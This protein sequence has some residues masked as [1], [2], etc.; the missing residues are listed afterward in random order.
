MVGTEKRLSLVFLWGSVG[1]NHPTATGLSA[2]PGSDPREDARGHKVLRYLRSDWA[3]SGE[4]WHEPSNGYVGCGGSRWDS[5]RKDARGHKTIVVVPDSV[6]TPN[7]LLIPA[8]RDFEGIG[9]E[10][11]TAIYIL[12]FRTRHRKTRRGPGGFLSQ[13]SRRPLVEDADKSVGGPRGGPSRGRS[14][15]QDDRGGP[16]FSLHPQPPPHFPHESSKNKEGAR[17]L[18]CLKSPVDRFW[19]TP[20][21][22]SAVLGADP[23]ED[24]RGHETIGTGSFRWGERWHE[25]SNGYG[26]RVLRSV[27]W[28]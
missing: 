11:S 17:R 1:T 27:V 3:H 25:P 14:G 13:I 19:Q 21:G 16:G 28:V 26:G 8:R 15:P 12:I 9:A 5:P 20:T 6:S 7:P 24:A 10:I 4:R 2:V 18:F 23:R 22:V